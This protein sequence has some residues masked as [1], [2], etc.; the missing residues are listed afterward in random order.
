MDLVG[1]LLGQYHIVE[2]IGRGGMAMV[3]KAYQPALDRHVALKVLMP[4]QAGTPEFRQRFLREA[5]AVAQLNH[6]NILP[7]ID[8]GRSDDLIYI[9][10]EYVSGGT[11][12]DRLKHAQ[13]AVEA[14]QRT[15]NAPELGVSY[16][17]LG[18]ACHTSN[19]G[20]RA[21]DAYEQSMALLAEAGEKEELQR[22]QEGY[23]AITREQS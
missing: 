1:R 6:P 22:A 4:Q 3:F 7:I 13:A 2:P 11:L 14:A 9:V 21:R 5:K 19:A 18:D 20:V 8:Y 12:S 16:R 17:V 10:M 15:G 23:T